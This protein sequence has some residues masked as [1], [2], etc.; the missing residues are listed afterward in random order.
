MDKDVTRGVSIPFGYFRYRAR[1]L[2]SAYTSSDCYASRSHSSSR[3]RRSHSGS[4]FVDAYLCKFCLQPGRIR[5][6]SPRTS[7]IRRRIRTHA[8]RPDDGRNGW[9]GTS[10][11]NQRTFSRYARGHGYRSTRCFGGAERDPERRSAGIAAGFDQWLVKPISLDDLSGLLSDVRATISMPEGLAQQTIDQVARF[12]A[13]KSEQDNQKRV[14][15]L[16]RP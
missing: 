15:R 9:P 13:L 16:D 10:R 1:G 14:E 2:Q 4:G 5:R 3:R 8:L 11:R 7:P 12:D 6:R